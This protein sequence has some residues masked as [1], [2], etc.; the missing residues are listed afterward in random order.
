MIATKGIPLAFYSDRHGIFQVN[1]KQPES[2]EEQLAGERQ[3]TQVGRA[4]QELGIQSIVAHSPQAKGRVERLWGTFQDR[5]VSELRLAGAATL[6]D[7]NRMLWDYLPRYNA[8]FAVPPA[9]SGSAYRPLE[10]GL[11]LD[12]VLC[13]KYQRTV[14]KDNTVRLGE[15]TLQLLPGPSRS[16]YVRARVEVQERLDG[17][18]VVAY[19]GSIIASREAPPHPAV[20]RARKGAWRQAT[21][22]DAVR[23]LKVIPVG[24]GDQ[25]K[26]VDE[27]GL[28]CADTRPKAGKPPPQKP[29]PHHPWRRPLLVT[30]S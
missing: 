6:E 23:T 10:P 15:H 8:R 9:H 1:P 2:L 24:D 4:L 19:Q 29:S 22:R 17:S 7:A 5:L 27:E 14:A 18:V 16:S 21:E 13:F 25:G 26:G 20:L 11:C 28:K 3:L 12:G 30:K